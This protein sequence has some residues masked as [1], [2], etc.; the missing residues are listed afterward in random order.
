M[1]RKK[2]KQSGQFISLCIIYYLESEH[3]YRITDYFQ[4]RHGILRRVIIGGKIPYR[5]ITNL[6][7]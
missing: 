2:P 1:K 6:Y 3:T 4:T 7:L 5:K